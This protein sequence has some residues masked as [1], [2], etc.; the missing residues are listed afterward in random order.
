MNNRIFI[1]IVVIV[2][3]AGAYYLLRSYKM[4]AP[5]STRAP[6]T[7]SQGQGTT[8]QS[9]S[10]TTPEPVEQNVVTYKDN[11]YSP[12]TI[13]VKVGTT[14]TFKNESSQ[15]M[16]TASGMH[17][18]HTLYPT[19]GG[20]IGS[21]FDACKGIQTGESWSFKFDIAGSWKY[22]NHLNPSHFGTVVV[23]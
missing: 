18:T 1:I 16:W 22:H 10:G 19:T 8:V 6:Q 5:S 14:V 2:I 7:A 15:S 23:E 4:G 13:N 11:G 3:V 12:S 9:P 17:P 21:T 20:C